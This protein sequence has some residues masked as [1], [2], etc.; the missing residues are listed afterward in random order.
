MF[1]VYCEKI[2]IFSRYKYIYVI[3]NTLLQKELLI[4]FISVWVEIKEYTIILIF[5]A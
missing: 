2:H 1:H 3:C 5:I 4:F